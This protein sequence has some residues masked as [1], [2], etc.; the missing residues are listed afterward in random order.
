[1]K[2]SISPPPRYVPSRCPEAYTRKVK[3][4]GRKNLCKIEQS[5]E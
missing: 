4:E 3:Q 2:W 5:E 1:M